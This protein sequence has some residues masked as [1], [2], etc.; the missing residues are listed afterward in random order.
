M[1]R[2]D[3][4]CQK[5]FF[6]LYMKLSTDFWLCLWACYNYRVLLTICQCYMRIVIVEYKPCIPW[7][8]VLVRA[9]IV[10]TVIVPVQKRY[11]VWEAYWVL[12]CWANPCIRCTNTTVE[13]YQYKVRFRDVE[14]WDLLFKRHFQGHINFGL[15]EALLENILRVIGRAN[16]ITGII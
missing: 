16:S 10:H 7:Y 6:C 13:E 15:K 8:S 4:L 2:K 11:M 1:T 9:S 3:Q 12:V 5:R 14:P